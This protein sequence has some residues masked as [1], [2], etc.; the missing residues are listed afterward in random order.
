MSL[1]W[2]E[3]LEDLI[4]FLSY[5]MVC[6]PD[7]FP[8]EDELNL[9]L[10]FEELHH[11]LDVSAADVSDPSI[12]VKC[13]QLANQALEHYRLGHVKQGAD[14]LIRVEQLLESS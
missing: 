13:R 4:E 2:C 6:A 14:A 11:G 1:H 8:S 9:E 10:A 3:N 5:V 12:L 7:R